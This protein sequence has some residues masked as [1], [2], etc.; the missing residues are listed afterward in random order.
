MPETMVLGAGMEVVIDRTS[1]DKAVGD[2]SARMRDPARLFDE[3]ASYFNALERQIFEQEG[4]ARGQAFSR[5][6]VVRVKLA[7]SSVLKGDVFLLETH[8]ELILYYGL[9][10]TQAK[11]QKGVQLIQ[12]LLD[13]AGGALPLCIVDPTERKP[14]DGAAGL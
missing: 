8:K 5:V 10:S 3:I 4:A 14:A 9:L 6:L 13:D 11:R 2:I 12:Q 7:A 1:L